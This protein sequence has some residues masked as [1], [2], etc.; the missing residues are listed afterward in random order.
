MVITAIMTT[1]SLGNFKPIGWYGAASMGMQLFDGAY[2]GKCPSCDLE[3]VFTK[4]G[5]PTAFHRN[6]EVFND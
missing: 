3:C 6:N 4:E 5:N 2:W 1:D